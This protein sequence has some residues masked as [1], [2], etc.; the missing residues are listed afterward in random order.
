MACD[1]PPEDEKHFKIHY[2]I[3]IITGHRNKLKFSDF[4]TKMKLLMRSHQNRCD[5]NTEFAAI[6]DF[7][8]AACL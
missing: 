5:L 1:T 3:K 4:T 2:H 6:L 7:L 8:N